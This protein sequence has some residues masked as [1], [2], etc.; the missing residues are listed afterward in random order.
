M[1]KA[2][3]IIDFNLYARQMMPQN[4]IDVELEGLYGSKVL[5][6]FADLLRFYDIY[7]NGA[8]F[9]TEG[10][11]GNYV[12][13]DLRFREIASIINKE[14]RFLFGKAP[15]FYVNAGDSNNET[16]KKNA[17]ILQNL[18]NNVLSRNL[19]SSKLVKAAKDCFIGRRIAYIVNFDE[20]AKVQ[21]ITFV[22]SLEFIYETADD[23]IDELTKLVIFYQLN[24]MKDKE[25]QRIYKKKYWMQ[26]GFCHVTEIVYDGIGNEVEVI[27][28]DK[29]TRFS[30]IPGGVIINDGLTGDMSG[31]SEV[32]QLDDYEA[33]FSRL[34]NADIDSERQNM[35]PIKW[36]RDMDPNS[37]K[38]LSVAPG[39]FW[40]LASDQ[41]QDDIFQGAVGILESTMS[42]SSPLTN[43]LNRIKNSMLEQVDMPD[44]TPEALKGVVSS[45]KTLKAI[46][47]GLTARC[48][49]KMLAWRPALEKIARIII[50]GSI[51]YPLSVLRYSKDKIPDVDFSIVVENNYLLPEDETEEKN[52]DLAEVAQQTMS[53][54]SYMKK[55]RGLNDAEVEEELRQIA[56][57]R[58]IIEDS[59][60][61]P[62]IGLEE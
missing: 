31:M 36:S 48:E 23:D 60:Y 44:T 17:T 39:A 53:K 19:F 10:S 6:E 26:E 12:P 16:N 29:T 21:K 27:E 4:I 22:P 57:E 56:I 58:Q 50:D 7:D 35:N 55:W 9:L 54:K 33:W 15:D 30:Y 52:N 45:G 28:K 51:L 43:T 20:L 32:E 40:D 47:W 46:Y 61:N 25:E 38:N 3:E 2:S 24:D 62:P 11:N 34:S 13:S 8:K 14:A 37:T 42:Y 18:V 49:E 59:F 5:S 41:N 1:K